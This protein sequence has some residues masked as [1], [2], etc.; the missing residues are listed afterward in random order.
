MAQIFKL[1]SKLD[2]RV[3]GSIK[4]EETASLNKTR[5]VGSLYNSL[6]SEIFGAGHFG[7]ESL[8]YS[9]PVNIGLTFDFDNDTYEYW[10][11]HQILQQKAMNFITTMMVF[12][13]I[14]HHR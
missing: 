7:P 9:T 3:V 5:V 1:D 4:L 10:T 6:T 2:G 8:A 11:V 14:Y 12:Q 13:E